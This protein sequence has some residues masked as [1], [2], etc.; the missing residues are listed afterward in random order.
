MVI[1]N[2]VEK[3]EKKKMICPPSWMAHNIHYICRMGSAAY[4][5]QEDYSDEDLYGFCIP[6][7]DIVFPHL[8]GVIFGY[9][10]QYERFDQYQQHHIKDDNAHGGR[11]I[12]Y[13]ITI[14]NIV[15]Y[16][17]LC[18]DGNPNMC[19]SLF[20][21]DSCVKTIT[22]VGQ[23]VRDNRHIF[24]SKKMWHTFHGYAWSQW[25]KVQG[26]NPE[27][28]RKELV[29]KMGYDTKYSY[30]LVRLLYEIEQILKEHDLDLQRHKE[31][32]KAIRRGELTFEE[33]NRWFQLK[34]EELEKLY[35][36]SNLRYSVDHAK[37]KGLLLN[38]LEHHYGD[39]SSVV[40][41]PDLPIKAFGEIRDVVRKYEGII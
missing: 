40:T 4:G 30:H 24:L 20:V 14:Y 26:K 27:G 18:A 5:V 32:L 1:M 12:E 34:R 13:D 31:H 22:P 23:M 15:R 3:L 33:I 2:I 11:G 41:V 39:L 36:K 25:K 7:K 19:D 9:D 35:N 10:S 16:F 29:E 37:I 21:N 38:C 8:S 6:K 28:K 17:K